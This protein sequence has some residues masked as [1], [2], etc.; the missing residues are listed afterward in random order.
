MSIGRWL[1]HLSAT[2][3]M[4]RRVFTPAVLARLEAAID[5]LERQHAGEL[6]LAIETAYELPDLWSGLAPRQRALE[7]FG[8][9]GV[10]DTAD[11][12]GVL[13]YL[14][15]ADR[16]VEIVADRGIAA[17]VTQPEWDAVS[18]ERHGRPLR[19]G[20]FEA[21]LMAGIAGV[22]RLLALHFPQRGGDRN[23][24]LNQPVLL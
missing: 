23:E 8:Q 11:N 21:G 9:L 2:R 17:R 5:D 15:M 7:V 14:C 6:R 18:R 13:I 1:R 3:W 10:W 4:T 22:N 24:Q 19:T 12:N 20:Q 16:D